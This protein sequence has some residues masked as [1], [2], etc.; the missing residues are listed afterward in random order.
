MSSKP[1]SYVLIIEITN[2]VDVKVGALGKIKFN[3]G[4][5]AYVGSALNGLYQRI[6]RHI[7][8]SANKTAKF[9]WH[10]DYL[11]ASENVRL[12]KILTFSSKERLECKIAQAI[13]ENARPVP[14]FGC[15]DCRCRG[16]LFQ[17]ERS[18]NA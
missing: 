13:A 18:T 11:L 2:S 10:I 17:I 4:I 12:Q 6:L 1:G 9:H 15:S 5:Y 8:T 3:K 7:R 16:H 14:H